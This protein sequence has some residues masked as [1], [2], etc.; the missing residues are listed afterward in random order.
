[1]SET[2]RLCRGTGMYRDSCRAGAFWA[3]CSC[4]EQRQVSLPKTSSSEAIVAIER[5][6]RQLNFTVPEFNTDDIE[7]LISEIEQLRVE[8][9]RLRKAVEEWT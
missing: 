3:K 4:A 1:M 7:T 8:N 5:V 2:C 6:T 9:E